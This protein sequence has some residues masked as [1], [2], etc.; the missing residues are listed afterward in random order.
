M[1]IWFDELEGF[2]ICRLNSF[3]SDYDPSFD[4]LS[5]IKYSQTVY[6]PSKSDIFCSIIILQAKISSWLKNQDCLIFVMILRSI[7]VLFN[8]NEEFQW[9]W[10]LKNL[11]LR[12]KWNLH[13]IQEM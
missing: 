4:R 3:H 12:Q 9:T 7:M 5:N 10:N 11:K 1:F 8:H 6:S 2:I 13:P